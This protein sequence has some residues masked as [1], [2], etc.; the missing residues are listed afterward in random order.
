MSNIF[1]RPLPDGTKLVAELWGDDFHFPGIMI[2]LQSP[3]GAKTG[4]CFAE[5]NSC[6]PEGKQVCVGAYAQNVDDVTYYKS[7]S[8]PGTESPDV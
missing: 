6:R 8:D 2:S 4:L 1:E 7:Y 3:D 5:Y